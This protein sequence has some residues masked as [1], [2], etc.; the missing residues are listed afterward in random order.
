L[1]A[2][3]EFELFDPKTFFKG[4]FNDEKQFILDTFWYLVSENVM[5]REELEN[6]T[7][8][9]MTLKNTRLECQK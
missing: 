2:P 6:K 9:S 1:T 7:K 8:V 5:I 3:K 4:K